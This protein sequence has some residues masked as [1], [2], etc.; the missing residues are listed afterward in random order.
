MTLRPWVFIAIMLAWGASTFGS[1]LGLGWFLNA[2]Y[3]MAALDAYQKSACWFIDRVANVPQNEVV[4][5]EQMEKENR[6]R[7]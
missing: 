4:T 1:G 5:R 7:R 3:Y 2:R 6:R